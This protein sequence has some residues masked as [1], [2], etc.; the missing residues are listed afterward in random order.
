MKTAIYRL[1]GLRIASD[2]PL[3]G[4]HVCQNDAEAHSDVVIRCAPIPE[5]FAS[6]IAKVRDGQGQHS[7]RYDG[8][9][10]LLEFP[11]VARFLLR[12]GKEILI[13]LAPSS[14]HDEVRAYL[15]GG[16]FGALCHQRGIIP[17]HASAIDIADGCVAFVGRSG[18]GKSTLAAT[19]AR[20][21]HGIV[22]D[23][24]CFL[25]LGTDGDVQ[26]WPGIS[27]IRLWEDAKV[28][29]GFGGPGVERE[30]YRYDKYFIPVSPPRN[31]TQSRRL[32]G[33]YR[34]QGAAAAEVLIQN[35]HASRLAKH[36]GY[37][38]HLFIACGA[39]ARAV[40]VFRFSRRLDFAVLG[41]GTEMLEN[42]LSKLC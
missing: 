3:F 40:P 9:E 28:A 5:G 8:K 23:D 42:H 13:D 21:G 17:L 37:S 20:H 29:L 34:L 6:A 16:V 19:L 30:I 2:F 25:Q 4:L 27:R 10:V 24:V 33:I 31:P 15:L 32:R 41:Q 14:D 11:D 39:A 36:L 38:P 22:T 1:G 18:A 12:A 35:V 26:V 7:G